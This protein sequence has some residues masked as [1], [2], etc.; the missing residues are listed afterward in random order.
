MNVSTTAPRWT[1]LSECDSPPD[2]WSV[3]PFTRIATVIAGQS[4]PSESYNRKQEGL[5]FLQGN[6]D[7]YSR[8]P[9]PTVWCTSPKKTASRGDTLISVRAPVGELNRA[10]MKYAIGRGLA[11]IRAK[12]C[13]GDFLYHALQRWRL[14]LQR[15][16]QGTTFDAIT[17]RHFAS[18]LVARPNEQAEQTAIARILDAVDTAL[19][20]T[21]ESADA[22]RTVRRALLQSSLEFGGWQGPWKDTHCGRIPCSWDAVSGR[23]AFVIVTGGCSSVDALKL[24][25]DD[26]APDT[27]FMKVDDFNDPANGRMIVQTQLGFRARENELFKVLP[28]GTVV[29]AKRGAA[30]MKNR[31]R[32]TA[33]PVSLDP[34]LMALQAQPGMH[35]EF[36]R[37]QLE[38]RNLARYVEDSGVPQL[39]NKDLYPRYF[40]VAPDHWQ[41]E[42]INTVTAAERVEDTL[43]AK[44]AALKQ[45][46][47]SLMHDLL[48]GKVRVGNM[49]EALAP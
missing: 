25:Q 3:V 10:D 2:G 15:V 45:V 46:K 42:I 26:A 7:F 11:A 33:V 1:Y 12:D 34:N 40:L 43:I 8:N 36:L 23:R 6:G 48:T 19:E 13:D 17:T 38:W 49:T 20:R 44:C 24:P 5:P 35:P 29:I 41:L 22:A 18:L 31:I 30:I 16:G 37:L 4:P 9:I 14:S 27:W 32:T 21:R 39:N 47:Q 28:I